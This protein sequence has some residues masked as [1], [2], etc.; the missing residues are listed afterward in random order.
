MPD[1]AERLLET[2]YNVCQK[3]AVNPVVQGGDIRHVVNLEFPAA[4]CIA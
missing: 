4:L 2:K 3:S 1:C